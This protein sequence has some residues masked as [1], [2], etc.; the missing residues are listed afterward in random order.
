M[1]GIRANSEARLGTRRQLSFVCSATTRRDLTD[2]VRWR[3]C[4]FVARERQTEEVSYANIK[5]FFFALKTYRLIFPTAHGPTLYFKRLRVHL[6]NPRCTS[7]YSCTQ[8]YI[9]SHHPRVCFLNEIACKMHLKRKSDLSVCFTK[10]I[11]KYDGEKSAPKSRF[12]SIV[13][14]TVY[15]TD[16][17]TIVNTED[18]TKCL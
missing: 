8:E 2:G 1:P 16:N 5:F 6:E 11:R 14:Q 15:L 7:Q 10:K 12:F 13:I 17:R 3:R 4:E 18:V 9:I